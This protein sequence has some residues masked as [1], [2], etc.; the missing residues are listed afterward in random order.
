MS[1]MPCAQEAVDFARDNKQFSY[2][3]HLTYVDGITPLSNISLNSIANSKGFYQS[4]FLRMK[5]FLRLIN[6]KELIEETKKQ[7][8]FVLDN[9]VKVSHLDS[10]TYAQ[11]PLFFGMLFR[12]YPNT[13]I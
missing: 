10:W 11:V 2:G 5:A 1:N 12:L 7:I 9:G 4:N 6:L 13:T 8:D 3:V